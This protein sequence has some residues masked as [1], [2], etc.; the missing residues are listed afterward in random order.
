VYIAKQKN[1]VFNYELLK[2]RLKVFNDFVSGKEL[3]Y[4]QLFGLVTNLI[5]AKG[6][7][8][9]LKDI[10]NKYNKEGLTAYKPEDFAIIPV[11]KK[12]DYLPQRIESFSP[13]K[14]DHTYTDVFDVIKTPRGIIQIIT[15][16]NKI[17][18]SEAEKMLDYEFNKVLKA[19]DNKIYIIKTQTAIGKSS[20]LLKLRNSTL[21][22]PTHKLKNEISDKMEVDYLV[23]PNLPVFT[24]RH[25]NERIEALYRIGLNNDVFLFLNKIANPESNEYTIEDSILAKEFLQVINEAKTTSKTVLTTHL[26]GLFDPYSHET[27]IFDEDPINSLISIKKF[28]LSDLF[29]IK[30]HEENKEDITQIIDIIEKTKPGVITKIYF[31]GINFDK[32]RAFITE[33]H[34]NTNLVQFFSAKAFYKDKLNPNIIHYLIQNDIPKEKKVVI[35]S[36]TPLMEV[37]K[38]LYSDR[39]NFIDIPLAESRGQIKQFIKNGYSRSYLK[40]NEVPGLIEKIGDKCVITFKKFKNK[41][42]TAHNDI[43]YGNCQGYDILKGKDLA[44][45]GTPHQNELKYFFMAFAM[46]V[47]LKP[48]N[49]KIKNMTIDYNGFRFLFSTYENETLRKIQLGIIE[50]ELVQALGRARALRTNAEVMVFSNLPLLETTSFE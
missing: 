15:P 47:Y 26:R 46:G 28:E 10:M 45:V 24:N 1:V 44:I 32:I 18:L 11:V 19:N 14:E 48:S 21:A 16:V 29:A 3:K 36:A 8:K 17:K 34:S 50:A 35:L 6:G 31:N 13:Y 23:V 40:N 7:E 33:F 12:Y 22:F 5:H 42:S 9:Y 37:F 27:I 39:V 49:S 25:I 38:L 41:F 2:D 30:N 20:K 43:H 4:V